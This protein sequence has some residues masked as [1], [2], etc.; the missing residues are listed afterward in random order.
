MDKLF[1]NYEV[2]LSNQMVK[3]LGKSI[4]KM[5]LMVACSVLGMSN[6]DALREKME[7]DPLPNSA[8]ESFTCE[9]HYR[10]SS[11]LSP[12][13]V[14]LITSEH[15]LSELGTKNGDQERDE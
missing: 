10:F 1:N 6:Q 11:F 2:K 13:T 14:G 4:I 15:Y 5:Y 7:S 12:L 8:I 3:S 9:M